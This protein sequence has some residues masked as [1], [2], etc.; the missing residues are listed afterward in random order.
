MREHNPLIFFIS[1]SQTTSLKCNL[2]KL[3]W[4][5][6]FPVALFTNLPL[7]MISERYMHVFYMLVSLM[8]SIVTWKYA[9]N[10]PVIR[11]AQVNL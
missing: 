9:V 4:D 11:Y 3:P 2:D 8:A 7:F 10:I 5:A 6:L 1:I